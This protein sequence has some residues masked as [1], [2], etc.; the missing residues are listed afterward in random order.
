MN[1]KIYNL[2]WI[3]VG[4]ISVIGFMIMVNMVATTL[5]AHNIMR[6][7]ALET[8][9]QH[10]IFGECSY[11]EI[12]SFVDILYGFTIFIVPVIIVALTLYIIVHTIT[13]MPKIRCGE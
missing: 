1:K 2:I 6:S 8:F 7:D 11:T 3:V 5:Y 4:I 13:K 9:N 10:C 12:G